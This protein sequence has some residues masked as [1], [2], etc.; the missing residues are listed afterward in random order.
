MAVRFELPSA[1]PHVA[2]VTMLSADHLDWHRGLENYLDCKRNIV[3]FQKPGEFAV[4]SVTS[5]PA[6]DLANFTPGRVV[7]YGFAAVYFVIDL[8]FLSF[9]RP[10]RRRLLGSGRLHA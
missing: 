9:I 8:A 5:A 4:R 1:R 3:R 10:L 7:L 6:R 2:V